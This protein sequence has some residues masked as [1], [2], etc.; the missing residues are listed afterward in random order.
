MII[1]L[2]TYTV[3]PGKVADYLALYEREGLPVQKRHI[4][5][6]VG[7]F[8]SEIGE[9]NQL[10][11]IWKYESLSDRERKRAAMEADPE[12]TAYRKRSAE[13]GYLIAQKNQILKSVPFSPLS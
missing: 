4:G 11:H 13:A 2:R 9:L 6:P 3:K 8:V 10:V 12:W 5:E 7:Y 1:D